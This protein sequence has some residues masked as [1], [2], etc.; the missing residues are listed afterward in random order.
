MTHVG[1]TQIYQS[2]FEI[3]SVHAALTITDEDKPDGGDEAKHIIG[4]KECEA[5]G[6]SARKQ[7]LQVVVK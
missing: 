5:V 7:V 4:G 6:M 3:D 2:C 1:D